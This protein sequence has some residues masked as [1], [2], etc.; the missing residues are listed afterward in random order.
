MEI[1]FNQVAA[2]STITQ[3]KDESVSSFQKHLLQICHVK[4]T[5]GIFLIPCQIVKVNSP[6]QNSTILL[7]YV[8][9]IKLFLYY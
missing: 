5:R 2:T 4:V 1:L 7:L 6:K 9:K 8:T 3:T